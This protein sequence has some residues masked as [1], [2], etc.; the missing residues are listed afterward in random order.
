MHRNLVAESEPTSRAAIFSKNSVDYP[1]GKKEL[2][3][4]AQSEKALSKEKLI[5]IDGIVGNRSS[6]REAE[7]AVNIQEGSL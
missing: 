2:Q 5:S 3:L 4:L 1:F 7:E 6:A